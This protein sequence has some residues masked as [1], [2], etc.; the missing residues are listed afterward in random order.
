MPL[1]FIVR[2]F[3]T[4]SEQ[5]HQPQKIEFL[6]AQCNDRP[7]HQLGA[8]MFVGFDHTQRK[9]R[10]RPPTDV[11]ERLRH[12]F[13]AHW[14]HAALGVP[15]AEVERVLMPGPYE[16]R[17]K[18]S[19]GF[20]QAMS[21]AKAA[22]GEMRLPGAFVASAEQQ[23][24]GFGAVFH[25]PLW[26][27]LSPAPWTPSKLVS[28]T[29][30]SAQALS[31]L[32]MDDKDPLWLAVWGSWRGSSTSDVRRVGRQTSLE[33]LACLLEL[34]RRLYAGR[35]LLESYAID[36]YRRLS[37]ESGTERAPLHAAFAQI[38][39][40]VSSEIERHTGWRLAVDA[41]RK[42]PMIRD[43]RS[44]S[45]KRLEEELPSLFREAT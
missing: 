15:F 18:E 8:W 23:V 34:R 14:L 30:L 39:G 16:R 29:H 19:G 13:S 5:S 37:E 32:R 1:S 45:L 40:S 31:H 7:R 22:R 33:S 43:R 25:S 36:I 3:P 2:I 44:D 12:R 20:K 11:G 35:G 38:A 27:L 21:P 6:A 28:A 24:A 17:E 41:A 4:S 42:L 9:G 26:A 10:G